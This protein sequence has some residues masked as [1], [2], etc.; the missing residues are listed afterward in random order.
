L[1]QKIEIAPNTNQINLSKAEAGIY[2]LKIENETG[3][4]QTHKIVKK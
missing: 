4:S 2:I 1:G 3:N